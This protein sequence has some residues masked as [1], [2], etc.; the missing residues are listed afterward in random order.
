MF[1]KVKLRTNVLTENSPAHLKCLMFFKIARQSWTPGFETLLEPAPH[2]SGTYTHFSYFFDFNHIFL[3]DLGAPLNF[4]WVFDYWLLFLLKFFLFSFY[5]NLKI[6][7][8]LER[9]TFHLEITGLIYAK[10]I[11]KIIKVPYF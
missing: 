4:C 1:R 6:S 2:D 7:I 8:W 11:T 3:F 9:C 5:I 10:S